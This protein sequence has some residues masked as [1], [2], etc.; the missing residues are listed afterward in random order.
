MKKNRPAKKIGIRLPGRKVPVEFAHETA[1]PVG[2]AGEF[3]DWRHKAS[4]TL[5]PGAGR[6][7]KEQ[8]LRL[9]PGVYEYRLVVDGKWMPDLQR[10][11]TGPNLVGGNSV[12]TQKNQNKETAA[13]E[14]MRRHG[15]EITRS[16]KTNT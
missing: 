4:S 12:L 14:I 3:N 5:Y 10:G 7:L 11:E 6:W 13:R 16:N 15:N 9:R 1:T 8:E 2:I